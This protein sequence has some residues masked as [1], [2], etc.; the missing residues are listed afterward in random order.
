MLSQFFAGVIAS[1]F[2]FQVGKIIYDYLSCPLRHLPGPADADLMYGHFKH[3]K[4][5]SLTKE[6]REEFGSTFQYRGLLNKR[7]LYTTDVKTLKHI[8]VDDVVYQKPP[9]ERRTLSQMVGTGILVAVND[10]HKRQVNLHTNPAF[11]VPQIREL[12]E[13]FTQKATQLRDIW[14]RQIGD[15]ASSRIDV[16]SWLSKWGLDTIGEAGFNYQFHALEPKGP[17]N[18][19]F[20]AISQLQGRDSPLAQAA[21]RFAQGAFPILRIF[22]TS[23]G[24][25][26]EEAREKM[27]NIGMQLL[28]DSKAAVKDGA[29]EKKEERRDLLSLMVKSNIATSEGSQKMSDSEFISHV[30]SFIVAGN[31]TISTGTSWALHMLSHNQA[32]QTK[33]REEL[34][35]I[36]TETPTMDELNSLTYLDWV[37]RETMRM[38]SPVTFTFRMALQDDVLPLSK[39]YVDRK[40][41]SHDTIP[42]RKGTIVRIPIAAVHRDKA[43]WGEDADEFRPERWED[44]PEAAKNIPSIWSNLLTFLAGP[45]NCIGYK[46]AIMEMKAILFVLFRAFEIEAAVPEEDIVASAAFIQRPRVRSEPQRTQMPLIVRSYVPS[47]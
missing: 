7:E 30:P 10:D 42:I 40:G 22:P 12:T 35:T 45:R 19:L 13:I 8:L 2:V 9:G 26:G 18:E 1:Y 31:E 14:T 39:P 16:F 20:Q 6:W 47:H 27:Y 24:K 43:I 38:Y 46:F 36:H 15:S 29:A 5:T 21:F 34:L 41:N 23:V 28:S 33:L 17:P 4:D 44:V 3:F 25:K 32:A 11:S 37:V